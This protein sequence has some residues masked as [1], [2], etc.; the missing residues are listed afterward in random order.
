MTAQIVT[1]GKREAYTPDV[2]PREAASYIAGFPTPLWER[3]AERDAASKF[4]TLSERWRKVIFSVWCD[5]LRREILPNV[6]TPD[7][8]L[9]IARGY[10][11]SDLESRDARLA[12]LNSLAAFESGEF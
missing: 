12:V 7:E 3:E 2:R 9:I 5:A 6:S 11:L 1:Q 4:D 10:T 8:A